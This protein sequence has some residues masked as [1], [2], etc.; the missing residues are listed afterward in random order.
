MK[1]LIN[2]FKI[3]F[4]KLLIQVSAKIVNSAP[5]KNVGQGWFI[6][7]EEEGRDC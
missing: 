5:G 2:I 3:K 1:M 7:W 6:L 4:S